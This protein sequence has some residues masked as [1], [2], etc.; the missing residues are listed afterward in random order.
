[1]EKEVII[2][3]GPNGAG[4][5]TF[6]MNLIDL[7]YI[8]HFINADEIAKEHAHLGMDKANIKASREF[9]KQLAILEQE[10]INFAFETTLSGRSHI[11]RIRKLQEKGWKVSLFYLMLPSPELSIS[12]VAERVSHGGHNIPQEDIKRRFPKSL[13]H[14]YDDYMPLVDYSECLLNESENPLTVFR[15]NEGIIKEQNEELFSY[16]LEVKSLWKK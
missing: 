3:A 14:Y 12:R 10:E 7:G 16:F 4:K 1:M 15:S 5:T 2:I 6:A 9:L 8:E 11:K 13:N